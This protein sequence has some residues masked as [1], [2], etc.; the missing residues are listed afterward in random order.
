MQHLATRRRGEEKRLEPT[1]LL[2]LKNV[3]G[4][5]DQVDALLLN[6]IDQEGS[7]T[8]AA[9]RARVSYRNAWDRLRRLEREMGEAV[10][11]SSKG[12][13]ERGSSRLT[14]FGLRL[15]NEYRRLNSYLFNAL[16]D[17][18]FWQHLGYRL[19]AR[20]RLRATVVKVVKGGVASEVKMRVSGRNLITSIISE[21]AVEEL[22]LKEGDG[23]YAI[24][25]AT[26][27]IIAKREQP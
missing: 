6:Y 24:I 7:I 19:S 1:F 20:N 4:A 14:E 23:V 10:I 22:G 11:E 8:A 13:R 26:E 15:L 18:D 25:K 17:R 16:G 2:T 21:D 5:L 3:G 27:V 9:R 12:G